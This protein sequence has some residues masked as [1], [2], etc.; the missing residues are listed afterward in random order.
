MHLKGYV[1]D[2]SGEQLEVPTGAYTLQVQWKQG[3]AQQTV[4]VDVDPRFGSFDAELSVPDDA[5][6]K[7]VQLYTMWVGE[8]NGRSN[9]GSATL[10]V[11]DPRPPTVQLDFGTVGDVM[12][13]PAGGAAQLSLGTT[14]Y[15][16]AA[17]AGATVTVQWEVQSSYNYNSANGEHVGLGALLPSAAADADGAGLPTS[18]HVDIVTAG[19][20][21]TVSVLEIPGLASIAK[22]GDTLS[23]DAEWVGPTREVVRKSLSLTISDSPLELALATTAA[24]PVPGLTFGLRADLRHVVGHDP[25]LGSAVA[26]NL[27]AWPEQ[28][29]ELTLAADGTPT[30]RGAGSSLWHCTVSSDGAT[31]VGCALS[32]PALGRFAL[33]G[34]AADGGGRQVCSAALL[35]RTEAEWDASPLDSLDGAIAMVPDA[36]SYSL[37]QTA[38][39]HFFNPYASGARA[40]VHWGNKLAKRSAVHSL[41]GGG[42]TSLPVPLGEECR[43]GC[44]VTVVL[45]TPTQAA[46]L[47][48]PVA[49][50][51]S[52]IFDWHA[53]RSSISHHVLAVPSD[54]AALTVTVTLDDDVAAPG[55]TAGFTIS[56]S[57]P[58]G[59]PVAGEV[60]AF[61]VDSAFL[62]LKP[63][64]MRDVGSS[65]PINL[66]DQS[67]FVASSSADGAKLFDAAGYPL[68]AE[69]LGD[70]VEQEPFVHLNQGSW[71][72]VPQGSGVEGDLRSYIETMSQYITRQ[73]CTYCARQNHGPSYGGGGGDGMYLDDVYLDDAEESF[74]GGGMALNAAM[75]MAPP[76]MADMAASRG[77]SAPAPA[78]AAA[79]GPSIPVRSAFETSPLFQPTLTVPRSGT[80]HV[81]FP[82]PDNVGAFTIRAYGVS[83][84]NR[85]GAAEAEQVVRNA[86]S[87]VA[88]VPRIVRVGDAF[89]CGFTISASDPNFEQQVQIDANIVRGGLSA[90]AASSRVVN[91]AGSSPQEVTFAFSAGQM[92][93]ASLQ[94]SA[95][96]AAGSDAFTAE[97][98]ILA[99][100]GSVFVATSMAVEGGADGAPPWAEGI[101][102]PD[103]VPGSGSLTISAGIGFLPTVEALSKALLHI[104]DERRYYNGLLLVNS[105]AP[106]AT[107]P[108]YP[109][110]AAALQA[111][112][113]AQVAVAV[114]DL[115]EFS[116]ADG[117]RYSRHKAVG[118][119]G[120]HYINTHLNA[121]AGFV[122]ARLAAADAGTANEAA[123]APGAPLSALAVQWRRALISGLKQ[124]AAMAE[125]RG[126]TF[127]NYEL[128][129]EARLVLGTGD[130]WET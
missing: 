105:I 33:V 27:Y 67:S 76:P 44:H 129:A 62:D 49:V 57:D 45:S 51:T 46:G 3:E 117:L 15:T 56:L 16:G 63:H 22:T 65:F 115:A 108:A 37:G 70:L 92:L 61:A 91:I 10:T 60:A 1:R 6:F 32:L 31:S 68:M 116:D 102:L 82:L 99:P 96:S 113:A 35:G 73:G 66:L 84:A 88:S 80:L 42:A 128:L 72:L 48:L 47:E 130:A 127:A 95:S 8:S 106:A 7:D 38:T 69:R 18:G 101:A 21:S 55:S 122:V 19:S 12:T 29:A 93:D 59:N 90:A 120:E 13:V 121:W 125:A 2:H 77:Q 9:I 20:G 25:V 83:A 50:P 53:A 34:C 39:L 43:G 89:E 100:Q 97:L 78:P 124:E 79:L 41:E 94:F 36:Q 107:L 118:L 104:P 110:G 81:P 23:L 71:P 14:T 40:L 75:E 98:P 24:D 112:A 30:L 74:G 87:L 103:A 123:W 52:P 11:A 4:Q 54:E 109:G 17:V 126:F 5:D 85:F 28:G 26:L 64:P 111:E 119:N 58:R 86:V 114:A